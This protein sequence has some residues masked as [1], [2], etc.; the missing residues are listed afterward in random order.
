MSK[1]ILIFGGTEVE[2]YKF[3]RYKV[4]ILLKDIDIG[5]VLVSNEIYSDEK[6]YKY[7]IGCL[8]NDHKCKPLHTVLPETS[9]YVKSYAGQNK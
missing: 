4:P 9:A 8:Y 3:H 6:I 1:E 5:N 2:A 7:F